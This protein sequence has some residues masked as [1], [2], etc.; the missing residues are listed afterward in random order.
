MIVPKTPMAEP[1]ISQR[2]MSA[3]AAEVAEVTIE[4]LRP[5]RMLNASSKTK[6][7][8]AAMHTAAATPN[9]APPDDLPGATMP[10]G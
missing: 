3:T 7:S 6:L 2:L 4:R 8:E 10:I 9:N 1:R 5:M